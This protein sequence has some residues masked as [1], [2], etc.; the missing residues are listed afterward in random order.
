MSIIAEVRKTS[1]HLT[2]P[3]IIQ[4]R[5]GINKYSKIDF[6]VKQEGIMIQVYNPPVISIEKQHKIYLDNKVKKQLTIIRNDFVCKN[7]NC[8]NPILNNRGNKKYCSTNCFPRRKIV[9]RFIDE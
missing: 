7:P 8:N 9:Y 3:I 2:I 4:E 1:K 6:V 5:L